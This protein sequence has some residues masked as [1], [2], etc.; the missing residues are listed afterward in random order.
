[1]AYGPL[2]VLDVL[3]GTFP[4]GMNLVGDELNVRAVVLKLHILGAR[5]EVI[6][7]QLM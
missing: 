5:M 7:T 4:L 3:N 1:M 6:Q 2:A